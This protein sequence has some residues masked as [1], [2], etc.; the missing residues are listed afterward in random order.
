MMVKKIRKRAKRSLNTLCQGKGS[1]F[2]E[3][4]KRR[5]EE[6]KIA[7]NIQQFKIQSFKINRCPTTI[8]LKNLE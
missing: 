7:R 2:A 5:R 1:N 4:G 6:G 8:F 3:M